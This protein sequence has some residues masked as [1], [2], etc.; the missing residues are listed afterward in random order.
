[1]KSPGD[2]DMYTV[3]RRSHPTTR[4]MLLSGYATHGRRMPCF[5]KSP[6]DNDMYAAVRRSH[7]TT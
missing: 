4:L 6:V 2:N 5:L 1:L 3:V 7:L